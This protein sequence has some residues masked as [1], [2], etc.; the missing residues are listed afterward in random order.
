MRQ[1]LKNHILSLVNPKIGKYHWKLD[2]K[3]LNFPEDTFPRFQ[4]EIIQISAQ[5]C[6]FIKTGQKQS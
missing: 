4:S 6:C 2:S 3:Y 5:T 1:H